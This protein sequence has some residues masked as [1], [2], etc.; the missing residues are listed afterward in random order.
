M[1]MFPN[2][3]LLL[4]MLG[5]IALFIVIVAVA[6]LLSNNESV[7]NL[8]AIIPLALVGFIVYKF[9]K[10]GLTA[11]LYFIGGVCVLAGAIYGLT[12]VIVGIVF[13]IVAY[14]MM[15]AWHINRSQ[16]YGK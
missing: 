10:A 15:K 9:G 6:A 4:I 8:G 3:K 7:A 1:G 5:V 2:L 11:I 16:L 14:A 13:L 12:S